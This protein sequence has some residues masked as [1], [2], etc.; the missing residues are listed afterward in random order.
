VI[1]V[2]SVWLSADPGVVFVLL[3]AWGWAALRAG[4]LLLA[5]TPRELGGRIRTVLIL[6][7]AGLVLAAT[8]T[9]LIAML[10]P[11][12]WWFVQEKVVLA[13]PLLLVPALAVVALSVPRLITLG[14]AVRAFNGVA[15]MPP[16]LRHAAAHPLVPWPVQVTARRASGRPTRS[17]GSGEL[18]GESDLHT[19]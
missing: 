10:P 9:V 13:L 1:R 7:T 14:R 19:G 3:V 5:A 6:T 17:A 15:A 18:R 16:S 4:A 12:G 8:R 2:S 11:A